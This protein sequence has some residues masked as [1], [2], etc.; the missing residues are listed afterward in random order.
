MAPGVG[1]APLFAGVRTRLPIGR[2]AELLAHSQGRG[3]GGEEADEQPGGGRHGGRA[4]S[5]LSICQVTNILRHT[6]LLGLT[7][8]SIEWRLD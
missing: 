2:Q 1:E 6:A 5:H 3:R 8:Q 4:V 7:L